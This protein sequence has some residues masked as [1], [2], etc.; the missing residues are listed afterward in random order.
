MFALFV[1]DDRGQDQQ[2]VAFVQTQDGVHNLLNRLALY[3]LA[4]VPA[5]RAASAGEQQAQIVVNLGYSTNGGARVAR[6]AF[7][8]D[9][10]RRTQTFDVIDLRFLHSA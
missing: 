8:V 2:T 1:F 5:V 9:G 4:T 3:G 7:L 10:D 6:H